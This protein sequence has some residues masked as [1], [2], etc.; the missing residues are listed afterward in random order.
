M[1]IFS[2]VTAILFAGAASAQK[3]SYPPHKMNAKGV[4][5]IRINGVKGT[6]ILNAKDT[7]KLYTIKVKHTKG[8]KGEDWNLSVERQG[9]AMVLEVFSTEY[10][11]E[12]R[13]QVRKDRWPEFDIELEG[14]S[15]PAVIAWRE[16]SIK[17]TDWSA[18]VE[19]SF[20]SGPMAVKGVRGDLKVQAVNSVLRVSDHKGKLDLKGESGRVDLFDIRGMTQVY[21]VNGNLSLRRAEGGGKVDLTSGNIEAIETS[22]DWQIKMNEGRGHLSD[23]KGKLSLEGQSANWDISAAAP[24]DLEVKNQSGEVALTWTGG[25][26]LFLASAQGQLQ[27]PKDFKVETREGAKVVE[28]SLN[29]KPKGQIFVRTDSGKII[30]R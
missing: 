11:K 9:P 3:A 26:K 8:R 19:A 7:A 30:W 24:L 20:L 13:R 1:H 18:N 5:E 15:K 23:S 12:W 2:L 21:W 17:V 4:A 22:G 28:S 10:G 6:L 27:V 25:A 14:P 29:E 16:G